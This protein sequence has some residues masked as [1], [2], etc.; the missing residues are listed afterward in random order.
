VPE[1]R[2]GAGLVAANAAEVPALPAGLAPRVMDRQA[3]EDFALLRPFHAWL[4]MRVLSVSDAD[5]EISVAWR[6]QF[7][8]NPE[9]MSTHGGILATLIDVGASYPITTRTGRSAPTLEM[10]VSYL[11]MAKPGVLRVRGS[12][13]EACPRRRDRVRRGRPRDCHRSRGLLHR[14]AKILKTASQAS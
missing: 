10:T 1:K 12:I 6:P 5:I 7:V 14:A 13:H 8:S 4:G 2:S 11:R 3:L 9:V